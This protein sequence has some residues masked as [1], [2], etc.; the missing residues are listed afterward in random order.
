[1]VVVVV[2]VAFLEEGH[3][4]TWEGRMVVSCPESLCAG[5]SQING[6]SRSLA[7]LPSFCAYPTRP[8]HTQKLAN[9]SF[10]W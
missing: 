3:Q 1:M 2:V 8:T 6:V 5:R 10:C 9:G 7:D 4:R